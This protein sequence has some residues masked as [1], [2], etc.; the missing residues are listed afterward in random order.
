MLEIMFQHFW[1][2]TCSDYFWDFG[3]L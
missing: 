2:C 1:K 3:A